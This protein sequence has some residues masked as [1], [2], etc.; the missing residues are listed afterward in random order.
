MIRR[1]LIILG[2]T[3]SALA[4]TAITVALVAYGNDYIYDFSTHQIIQK[5]HVIIESAPSGIAVMED[6]KQLKKKTPYTAAYKVGE[7]TFRLVK[8][9]FE[10]WEK[11]MRVTAGRVTLANYVIMVPKTPQVTVLDT[12]VNVAAQ[13]ISKDHRHLAY[14]TAGPDSALYTLDLGSKKAVKLYTAKADTAAPEQLREV[15]WS[16]D[17]T[18]LLIVSDVNGVPVHRLAE[19]GSN[20]PPVDLTTKFGFNLTGLQFSG[21]NWRQLYWISPDGLRRLD[22]E[23]GT[24]SAVIAEKVNQF[25]VQPDRVLYVQQ[26][27]LGRSLWSVDGRGK[28]QELIQALVE[29]D[30]YTVALTQYDGE[31][32]LAVVPAKTGVATLYSDIFGDTPQSKVVAHGVTGVSFS[33]DG[34]LLALTSPT[35]AHVYDLERSKLDQS[36]VSYALTGQP[37]N[38]Q[39]MTWFDDE[40]LLSSRDGKLYWSEFD[41]ANSINLGAATAGLPA[42]A[43]SGKKNVVLYRPSDKDVKV[44]QLQIRQ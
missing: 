19:A 6:G 40:H 30:S 25:W 11:V 17:A 43:D 13:A 38:L 4:I 32:E 36:F 15:A 44:T 8:D 3:G 39:V 9:K 29:S 41:G 23:A 1:L 31:D 27:E 18:H 35:T 12:R 33:P 24:V 14:I 20:N 21:S 34:H 22:A 42:Y 37:G 28:R 5:G 10:P 7:H 26:T 16:D 2:Y